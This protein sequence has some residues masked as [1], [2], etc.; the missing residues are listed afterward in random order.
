MLPAPTGACSIHKKVKVKATLSPLLSNGEHDC[1]ENRLN[2]HTSSQYSHVL[3]AFGM[4][5]DSFFLLIYIVTPGFKVNK[6]WLRLTCTYLILLTIRTSGGPDEPDRTSV[7]CS[8]ITVGSP[9]HSLRASDTVT[10]LKQKIWIMPGWLYH[11][12]LHGEI[13][14]RNKCNKL[15]HHILSLTQKHYDVLTFNVRKN[16]TIYFLKNVYQIQCD[17]PSFR[18]SYCR[19]KPKKE[20]TWENK[21]CC[22]FPTC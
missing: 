16:N 13:K 6:S 4:R 9:K 1:I 12:D 18:E 8:F 10:F 2:K 11:L 20:V 22:S 17:Q 19:C 3:H 5:E 21:Q 14:V 15:Y 7:L